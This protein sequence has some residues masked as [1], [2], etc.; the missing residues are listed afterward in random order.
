MIQSALSSCTVTRDMSDSIKLA[1]LSDI[2]LST[3][4]CFDDILATNSDSQ[5]RYYF[6]NF[7]Q[8]FKFGQMI[9]QLYGFGVR[10]KTTG[11]NYKEGIIYK[12]I[13][14]KVRLSI[15]FI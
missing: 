3:I 2:D 13:C 11:Y 10:V 12:Y 1:N 4:T 9:S 14:C 5:T 6:G 7:R 8:A 15:V